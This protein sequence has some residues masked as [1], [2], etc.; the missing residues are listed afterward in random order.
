MG[1]LLSK[2]AVIFSSENTFHVGCIKR[3]RV[4][5]SQKH[6]YQPVWFTQSVF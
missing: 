3:E 4:K 1:V 5:V 2:I 6:L